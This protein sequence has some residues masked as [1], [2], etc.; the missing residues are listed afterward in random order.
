M[1]IVV[2]GGTGLIG[3]KLIARLKARGHDAVAASPNTGVNAVTGEGL[4]AALAGADVVVDVTN[5]PSWEAQAVLDFFTHSTRNLLAAEAKAGVGHHVALS[6][7]GTDRPPGND[8]FRAKIAQEALITASKIPW[9]IVRSTQFI[10]FIPGIADSNTD[11]KTVH[12]SP[13]KFQPIAADDVADALAEVVV[14]P[15]RMALMEIAGP[16]RVGMSD[17]VERFLQSRNDAREVVVDPHAKYFGMELDDVVLN[18]GEHP[19]L[20]KIRVDDWL[21][22]STK[23]AS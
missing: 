15:P 3:T 4:D 11:G 17:A 19:W 18:P 8:Y 5:S 20:G 1:K 7:V 14:A 13:A 10:E 23:G 2:I 6:I 21:A 9:T 16:E 22:A 12:V